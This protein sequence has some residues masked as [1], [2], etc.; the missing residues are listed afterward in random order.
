[1]TRVLIQGARDDGPVLQ[2]RVFAERRPSLA[3]SGVLA[4]PYSLYAKLRAE[5]PVYWDEPIGAWIVTRYRDVQHGLKDSLLSARRIPGPAQVK[6]SGLE[7]FTPLF[8][9]LAQMMIFQDPP[10]HSRIRGLVNTVF[11]PAAIERERPRIQQAV[12]ELVGEIR[13]RRQIDVIGHFAQL[14]PIR[15][16]AAIL[17]VDREDWAKFKHWSTHITAFL[18]GVNVGPDLMKATARSAA[19]MA[20]YLRWKVAG[21]RSHADSEGVVGRLV[22]ARDA[23]QQLTDDEIIAACANLLIAGHETTTNLIG[24]AV[25]N[26]CRHPDQRRKL[27][28][29][30]ALS[31]RAVEEVLRYDSPIQMLAR[32]ATT[33]VRIREHQIAPGSVV[34]LVVGAANRD[35]EVFDRPDAFDIE[36]E[37]PPHLSFGFGPH[38]CIGSNLA[39]VEAELVL[40]AMCARLGDFELASTQISWHQNLFLRGVQSLVIGW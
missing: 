7:G 16:I 36:R 34:R 29:Q 23:G 39:R 8:E 27:Q 14:L 11:T 12:D 26:L 28:Q 3:D 21:A 30:P 19:E 32:V 31:A 10:S 38:F 37:G 2:E 18:G 25:L 1:M 24:N 13:D 5:H 33:E 35:G 20:D 17:G 40:G 4:D 6:R 15:V 9:F 22:T